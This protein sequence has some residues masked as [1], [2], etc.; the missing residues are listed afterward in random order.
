[1][2][3]M[4]GGTGGFISVEQQKHRS[5][6]GGKA[7]S[8]KLKTDVDFAKANSLL[9][10][11]H[12]KLNHLNGKIR[13]DTFTGRKY[14]KKSKDKM[15]QKAKGKIGSANS[16]YGTCWITKDGENKKIK[17]A[18]LDEFIFQGWRLGRHIN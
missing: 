3:I 18:S 11:Y 4:S 10:S 1:M 8:K 9:Q 13:Y 2:N 6:C 14:S 7:F 12:M 17:K 16:Q 15:S 5:S